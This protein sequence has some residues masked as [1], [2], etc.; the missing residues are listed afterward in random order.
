MLISKLQYKTQHVVT[1]EK[2]MLSFIKKYILKT[3]AEIGCK[4]YLSIICIYMWNVGLK[5]N[6]MVGTLI[7]MQDQAVLEASRTPLLY[8]KVGMLS[9]FKV[10]FFI[11]RLLSKLIL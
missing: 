10:C 7:L 8:F 4:K 2:Y 6:E 9:S 3:L 5:K 1:S 11:C